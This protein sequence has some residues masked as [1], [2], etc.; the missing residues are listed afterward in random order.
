MLFSSRYIGILLVLAMLIGITV[1][2]V[3]TSIRPAH[4][5]KWG[6][7]TRCDGIDEPIDEIRISSCPNWPLVGYCNFSA[8][9]VTIELF[10]TP[11]KFPT[12]CPNS[13][14]TTDALTFFK[15]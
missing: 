4:P 6:I 2:F 5:V 12:R 1:V 9:Q 8:Y 7:F 3:I 15:Y 10:F 13:R 11:G 14:S